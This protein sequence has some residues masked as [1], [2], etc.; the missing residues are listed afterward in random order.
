MTVERFLSHKTWNRTGYVAMDM[1][2]VHDTQPVFLEIVDTDVSTTLN[3]VAHG[4]G[5]IPRG[6][7][8]VNMALQNDR[9][10][11]CWYRLDTDP[12]WTERELTLR[13]MM[14]NA[15]VL[16]EVF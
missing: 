10:P 4:L 5:R 3:T 13:F 14:D 9:Q 7:R 16:L 6:V 8:L 1:R 2:V 11:V 15:R 12:A